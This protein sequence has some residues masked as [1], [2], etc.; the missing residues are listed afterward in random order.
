MERGLVKVPQ[1][2]VVV[3]EDDVEIGA[4]TTIDRA[5]LAETRIGARTK[6]DNQVHIGHNVVIGTDCVIVAQVGIAGSVKIGRGVM[7]GGKAGIKDHITIGDGVRIAGNSG[8]QNNLPPGAE[9][10]GFPAI[11]I[12]KYARFS[13]FYRQFDDHWKKLKTVLDDIE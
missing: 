2:G 10:M 5:S 13:N 1:V 7:I 4:N 12:K 3:I 9:V 11:P 6:I 8:V